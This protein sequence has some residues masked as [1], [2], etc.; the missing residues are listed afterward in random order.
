MKS[1]DMPVVA[2]NALA[3]AYGDFKKGYTIVDRI[4]MR[5]IRDEVTSKPFVKFYTIKRTGGD[6]VTEEAIKI[7]KIAV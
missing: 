1:A 5:V 3:M 6:V 2:A 4:G 7:Q